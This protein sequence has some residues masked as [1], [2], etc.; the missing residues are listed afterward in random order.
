MVPSV[1]SASTTCIALMVVGGE[2]RKTRGIGPTPAA[3]DCH[4]VALFSFA[5]IAVFLVLSACAEAPAP[6][7]RASLP[8]QRNV[9]APAP[10]P[11]ATPNLAQ[12]YG[13]DIVSV[14][15]PQL[16]PSNM[17]CPDYSRGLPSVLGGWT[18]P[19]PRR[20]EPEAQSPGANARR[21]DILNERMWLRAHGRRD[22]DIRVP[23]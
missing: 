10:D 4:R 14:A 20:Q 12:P 5:A 8:A 11:C 13:R 15:S 17:R 1:R 16:R 2:A 7:P 18:E 9:S 19:A 3:P 6:E 21:N 22:T 23:H